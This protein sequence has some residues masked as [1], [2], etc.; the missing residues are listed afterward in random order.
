MYIG[1]FTR[2]APTEARYANVLILFTGQVLIISKFKLPE[3][4][5]HMIKTS[6]GREANK[7]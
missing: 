6:R 2:K 5:I 4:F 1:I 3:D 7:V